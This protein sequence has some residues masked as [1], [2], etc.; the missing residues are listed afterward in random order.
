MITTM[1]TTTSTGAVA[2]AAYVAQ[3]L[4]DAMK[5]DTEAVALWPDGEPTIRLEARPNPGPY[6]AESPYQSVD[7][8]QLAD[9]RCVA[10]VFVAGS[11][12]DVASSHL[13]LVPSVEA[14]GEKWGPEFYR[15]W[16]G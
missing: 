6:A 15:G 5:I 12:S 4:R 14:A 3:Q 8:W 10:L 13:M 2:K 16:G 11:P 7:L 1:T 9:G